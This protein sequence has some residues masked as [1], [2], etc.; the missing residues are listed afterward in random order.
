MVSG[1]MQWIRV[2]R[3]PI[4]EFLSSQSVDRRCMS[5]KPLSLRGPLEKERVCV[6]ECVSECA[7]LSLRGPARSD[8]SKSGPANKVFF[9]VDM[10]KLT[11]Y[12]QVDWAI[13]KSKCGV[14]SGMGC[15]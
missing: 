5:I 12:Y 9:K 2:S 6:R 1:S 7:C 3:S 11:G 4:K 10:L 8:P 14:G 13:L 15:S